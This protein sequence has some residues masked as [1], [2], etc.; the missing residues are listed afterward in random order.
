MDQCAMSNGTTAIG[1]CRNGSTNVHKDF[2]IR[3][4]LDIAR[5]VPLESLGGS[6]SLLVVIAYLLFW[7]VVRGDH[8]AQMSA[9]RMETPSI[10]SVDCATRVL[11]A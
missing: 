10:E 3:H 1:W 8:P 7:G 5:M 4:V 6:C 9:E 11:F 2:M